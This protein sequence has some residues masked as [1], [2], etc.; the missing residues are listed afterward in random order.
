MD[1]N[2]AWESFLQTGSVQAYLDYV[3][4][5]GEEERDVTRKE[6][7]Y[8]NGRQGPGGFGEARG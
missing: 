3:R 7:R 8:E 2:R 5:R 6:D 4:C 1:E